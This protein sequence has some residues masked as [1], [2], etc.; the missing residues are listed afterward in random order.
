[1]LTQRQK[2][3]QCKP[4]FHFSFQTIYQFCTRRNNS[5][6][7]ESVTTQGGDFTKIVPCSFDR[8]WQQHFWATHRPFE[9]LKIDLTFFQKIGERAFWIDIVSLNLKPPTNTEQQEGKEPAVV[10]PI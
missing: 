8:R 9:R 5:V 1:M 3:F 4:F 2:L 7:K 10:P 6:K